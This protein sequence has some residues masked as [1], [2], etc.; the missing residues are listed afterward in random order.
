MQS[1]DKLKVKLREIL[2]PVP[3][4]WACSSCFIPD[5]TSLRSVRSLIFYSMLHPRPNLT[6]FGVVPY[7]I[8]ELRPVPSARACSSCFIPDPTSLRS[9]RSSI[10]YS[11]L[12]P[13]PNLTS[14]G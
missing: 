11:M 7:T 13:R 8:D 6:S 9:V 12:H 14:F 2:H 4:A 3:L 5:P 1:G 10:F